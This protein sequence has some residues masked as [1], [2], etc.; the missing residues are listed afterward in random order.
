MGGEGGDMGDW[1]ACFF[2]AVLGGAE[3]KVVFM[4]SSKLKLFNAYSCPQ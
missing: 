2:F 1:W 3:L 4:N